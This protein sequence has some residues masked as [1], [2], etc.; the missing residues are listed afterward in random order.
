VQRKANNGV[1]II[2]DFGR[3]RSRAEE[4]LN[5]CIVPLD[6]GIDFLT[7]AGGRKFLI[8]FGMLV[9]FA[10]RMSPADLMDTALLRRIQTGIKVEAATE[11]QF[12]EIF[13]RVAAE[14]RVAVDAAL[15]DELI[16]NRRT[17]LH[18]ALSG[19]QPRDLINQVCWTARYKRRELRLDRASL[20]EALDA[21]FLPRV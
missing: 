14:R 19:C 2:D 16:E 8:P 18:P 9:V 12:S 13:R 21:Y 6:R 1:L 5:R 10:T 20:R 17:R 7:R 11:E 3:Q 15:I 4:L